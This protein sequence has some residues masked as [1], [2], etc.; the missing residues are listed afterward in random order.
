MFAEVAATCWSFLLTSRPASRGPPYLAVPVS[1]PSCVVIEADHSVIWRQEREPG[2]KHGE[3]EH[4][5]TQSQRYALEM[6]E[7]MK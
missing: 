4:G 2:I 6:N 5:A 3:L 1:H 7:L